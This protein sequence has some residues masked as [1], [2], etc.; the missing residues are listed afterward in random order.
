MSPMAMAPGAERGAGPD[1]RDV[2]LGEPRDV[3]DPRDAKPAPGKDAPRD[4]ELVPGLDEGAGALRRLPLFSIVALVLL[5]LAAIVAF[6]PERITPVAPA[7]GLESLPTVL[8]AWREIA[9]P[10]ANAMRSDPA[11]THHLYRAYQRDGDTVWLSVGYYAVLAAGQ[12]PQVHRLV[13]PGQGWADLS[14]DSIEIPVGGETL[15]ANLVVMRT[16]ER[17]TATLYW[18]H[19]NGRAVASDHGYRALLLW[20]RL[21]R[22]RS[23]VA[24]V[25]VVSPVA[26]GDSQ[27]SLPAAVAAQGDFLRAFYPALRRSL[28]E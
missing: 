12:H 1:R 21:W 27:A 23:N 19:L 8:G 15:P 28:P 7:R 14:V 2:G 9:A 16:A 22:Q 4:V 3:D 18:Y 20:N 25:R 6:L 13:I 26:R 11:A 24:V 5:A 17:T 10:P